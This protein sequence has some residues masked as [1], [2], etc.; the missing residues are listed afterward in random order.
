M[1]SLVTA[2]LLTV[3]AT[4]ASANAPCGMF[5]PAELERFVGTKLSA[6]RD[7]GIG[8]K[9][10]ATKDDGHVTVTVVEARSHEP[11][12][13]AKGYRLLPDIG[14]KGFVVPESG[15]LASTIV[16]NES[17]LVWIDGPT[18]SEAQVIALLQETIRRRG[19]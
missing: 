19:R 12:T 15:W 9:W 1:K 13:K 7:G 5:K 3:V 4:A 14:T 11:R 10:W 2:V 6:G 16:G 8:C 18:A 17:V